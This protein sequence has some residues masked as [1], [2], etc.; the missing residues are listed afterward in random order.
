MKKRRVPYLVQYNQ[1]LSPFNPLF[2][3]S[4]QPA[5]RNLRLEQLPRV[6][7]TPLQALVVTRKHVKE[8]VKHARP[9]IAG[10]GLN[11]PQV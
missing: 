2:R 7:D 9:V 6:P 10:A 11:H 8:V 4:L 3:L 1:P 5:D